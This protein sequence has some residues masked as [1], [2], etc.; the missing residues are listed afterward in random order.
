MAVPLVGAHRVPDALG[1]AHNLRSR[2]MTRPKVVG[3]AKRTPAFSPTPSPCYRDPHPMT[4]LTPL[5]LRPGVVSRNRVWL[6]P[7]TNQQS[8]ADGTLSDQEL[9]FL[10]MRADGGFGLVETCAA[11]VSQ[12]GKAWP[13]ELGVHDDAMIPGLTRLARRIHDGGALASVQ[14]FHGGLRASQAVS[15]IA[16]DQVGGSCFDCACVGGPALEC[17]QVERGGLVMD[18]GRVRIPGGGECL[19]AGGVEPV[20]K[21]V[22][23]R[24]GFFDQ[25]SQGAVVSADVTIETVEFGLGED[26]PVRLSS[27]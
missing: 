14:L 12:D 22:V 25:Q 3:K 27:A 13:G 21:E 20:V 18:L 11:Y 9:H 8:H 2:G 15:G 19:A 26:Q 17:W 6:A 5:T 7:L 24:F 16:P 23:D 1:L 10:A 4:L